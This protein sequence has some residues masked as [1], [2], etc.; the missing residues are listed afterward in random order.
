[1]SGFAKAF[2]F[3]WAFAVVFLAGLAARFFE[4]ADLA[5][6]FATGLPRAFPDLAVLVFVTVFFFFTMG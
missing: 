1:M 4:A 2:A 5:A 6:G 3:G